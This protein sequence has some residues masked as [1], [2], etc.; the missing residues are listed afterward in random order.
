MEDQSDRLTIQAQSDA[1]AQNAAKTRSAPDSELSG[2][3]ASSTMPKTPEAAAIIRKTRAT[4][5]YRFAR[6]VLLGTGHS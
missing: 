4:R 3:E 2:R 1:S 5:R 6:F